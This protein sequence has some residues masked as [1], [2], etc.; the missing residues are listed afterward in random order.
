MITSN[1]CRL[2]NQ[3]ARNRDGGSYNERCVL[4]E[5]KVIAKRLRKNIKWKP[6]APLLCLG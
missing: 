1:K 5:Q 6:F 4:V 3:N 2:Q